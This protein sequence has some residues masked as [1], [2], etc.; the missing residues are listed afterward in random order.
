MDPSEVAVDALSLSIDRDALAAELNTLLAERNALSRQLALTRER[1]EQAQKALDTIYASH[2]WKLLRACCRLRDRLLPLPSRRRAAAHVVF[3]TSLR[4]IKRLLGLGKYRPHSPDDAFPLWIAL[5]EPQPAELE[6]QRQACFPFE[7]TISLVVPVWEPPLPFLTAMLE[8]VLG[9]TYPRWELCLADGGSRDPAVRE[10]LGR[11]S[12]HDSHIKVRFLATNRGI[13][14]N[15][16]EALALATGD[17][18]ALLDQDD[19]LAPFALHEVVRAVNHEP[20][21]D[22]LYSDEDT[23]DASGTRRA[24][25][26]FKPDWSPDTLRSYN[27]ICHLA[28]FRR[29]LVEEIGGFRPGFEGS[30][31]YDLILRASE[32]ARRIVHIPKVLY[33]WRVHAGS[34]TADESVK[35]YA[36]HSAH[37]ALGNHLQRCGS[38]GE[39]RDGSRPGTYQVTYPIPGWPLV[40]VIIP[41]RDHAAA[42]ARCVTSVARSTYARHEILIVENQSREPATFAGYEQL[43][44]RGNVRIV[45]WDRPFN[46]A[47]VNNDA[48]AQARGD[49]LLFLNNDVEAINTDWLERLLEHALRPEV[50]AVGAKLCY[51]DDTIQHAGV[52]LGVGGI[53]GHAH[54]HFPRSAAGY[55]RRL[56]V[57]QNLS[58][59]T[60]ACL[61]IR[62]PVFEEVG[63]FD[64]RF[65]L[66]YNDVDLCLRLRQR[67]YAII[68]TPWAE[69]YHDESS[70]R[71]SDD[72][73]QNR[74]QVAAE[75]AL[76]RAKWGELLRAG[77]PYYN[78]NLT[79][80]YEDF[81][82]RV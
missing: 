66:I 20:E 65:V 22:L 30:Q 38:P 75:I 47:A 12:R 70:T 57:V 18:V 74:E 79:L 32:R 73:P 26:H 7:P 67:G 78:P 51:R 50:G 58:A 52:I 31:D 15:S 76:L 56:A 34:V 40:S 80:R 72:R 46:F 28:V 55:A 37:K 27:Y 23:I 41:N 54:R 60:G 33:H 19:T 25:P 2:G 8:S 53:A 24:N 17:Y 13:A 16:Q 59:V 6:E 5:N 48:A 3:R 14:G 43:R 44:Q 49:V 9:Q 64:E 81:S 11:Y 4:L 82:L 77:D 35:G 36:Y 21:A 1:L 39:V 63:G 10:M 69:L 42:L 61:M 62:K 45:P 68:W 29:E 71:G